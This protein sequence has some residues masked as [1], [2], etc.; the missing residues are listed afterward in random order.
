MTPSSPSNRLY[1][2]VARELVAAI[3]AGRYAIGD[4]LPAER[5]LALE[6]DVSRP[7]VREAIIALEAQGLVEVRL[8][9]GAYVRQIPGQPIGFGITAFE[10]VEARL[11]VEG[12][13]AALAAAQITDDELETLS[14]LVDQIEQGHS[15]ED[16]GEEADRQFHLAIAGATRNAA[17]VR[18]VDD[19]WALRSNSPDCA[20]LHA[21]A[22]A[23]RVTP[24]IEEHRMIVDALRTRD[25][26][27]AREAMRAHLRSVLDQLLFATEEQAIEAARQAVASTRARFE[28]SGAL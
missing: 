1:Q 23:A 15:A 26:A 8:G 18:I 7:T 21:R 25:P 20:I 17:I 3:A 6:F 11:L 5:E 4:R 28:R 16:M 12:E 10:V 27:K 19:L 22:R 14:G 9:S 2:H 13:G 24:I